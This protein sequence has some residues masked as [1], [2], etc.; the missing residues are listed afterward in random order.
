M[1]PNGSGKSVLAKVWSRPY[2]RFIV[3]DLKYDWEPPVKSHIIESPRELTNKTFDKA[4]HII[5]RPKFGV[6]INADPKNIREADNLA[7][8]CLDIGDC[9]I[10]YD[11]L[12]FIAPDSSYISRAPNYHLAETT[13]RGRGVGVWKST[14]RP[15][16]VPFVSLSESDR[17]VTFYLRTS[18]DRKRAEEILSEEIPWGSLRSLQYSF[19]MADDR[20]EW[21]KPIVLNFDSEVKEKETA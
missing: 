1:G 20:S 18:E 11:D 14:Q 4:Q 2:N 21:L 3:V 12:A 5:Y 13:G 15:F 7:A 16:R 8:R 9:T 19:V 10:Y 17:R 6:L